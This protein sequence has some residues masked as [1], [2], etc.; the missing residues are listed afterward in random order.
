MLMTQ[1][2]HKKLRGL[3]MGYDYRSNVDNDAELTWVVSK[4]YNLVG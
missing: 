4:A 1:K 3:A 2:S